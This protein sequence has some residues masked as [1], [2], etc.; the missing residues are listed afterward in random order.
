MR[1]KKFS[2]LLSV[3]LVFCLAFVTSCSSIFD[4][5]SGG[6][7][8]SFRLNLLLRRDRGNGEKH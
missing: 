3:I 2:F 4:S 7:T 1:M 6:A 5:S 8:V